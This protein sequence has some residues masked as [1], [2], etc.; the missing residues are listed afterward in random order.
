MHIQYIWNMTLPHHEFGEMFIVCGILYG[1][2]STVHR[3][4]RIHFA[5]DLYKNELQY[6]NLP[7]TNPFG[8]TAMIQY[9]HKHEVGWTIIVGRRTQIGRFFVSGAV[10]LGQREPADISSALQ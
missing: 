2:D 4:S 5:L 10:H 7:F 1:V 9:N 6:I 3:N 8:S